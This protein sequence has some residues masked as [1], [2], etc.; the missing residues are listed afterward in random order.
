MKRWNHP[1]GYILIT[2][3][4]TKRKV[5]EHR[6]VM[7][8]HLGRIL[9]RNEAVHHINGDKKDNRIENLKLM[10]FGAHSVLHNKGIAKH[11]GQSRLGNKNFIP[12]NKGKAKQTTC[13][14]AHCGNSFTRLEKKVKYALKQG[15]KLMCSKK[16]R[17]LS[18][19]K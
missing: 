5:L 2:H 4:E 10:D 9:Q 16:C 1:H 17:A 3:P 15:W 13:I 6:Y 12:W 18:C 11:K 7:E 8:Q 19:K 14:C